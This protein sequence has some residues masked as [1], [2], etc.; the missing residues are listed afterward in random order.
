MPI[1]VLLSHAAYAE[2]GVWTPY[3]NFAQLN[4]MCTRVYYCGPKDDVMYSADKKIVATA[5]ALVAGVCSADGGPIDGCNTC[6][7]S[8][9]K[10][11]CV[12]HLE[13]K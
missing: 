1:L 8:E 6:L 10:E 7:T 13:N 4:V 11:K 5:N 3:D 9:P 2:E 12:W